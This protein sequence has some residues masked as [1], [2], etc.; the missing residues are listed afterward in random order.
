MSRLPPTASHGS[1][2]RDYA[3][4]EVVRTENGSG[5]REGLAHLIKSFVFL[6]VMVGIMVM[7]HMPLFLAPEEL[8]AVQILG[9]SLQVSGTTTWM[10]VVAV[11]DLLMLAA[12]GAMIYTLIQWLRF[13]RPRFTVLTL[14][15]RPGEKLQAVLEFSRGVPASGETC[16]ALHCI[17][18]ST[19]RSAYDD[20]HRGALVSLYRD[21][22]QLDTKGHRIHRL[23]FDFDL[24]EDVPSTSI[25]NQPCRIWRLIVRIPT[26]GLNYR[27]EFLVP[28]YDHED[29][30][31]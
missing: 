10:A 31:S 15:A 24:P 20:N 17:D 4:R 18:A 8:P 14:P 26:R 9:T 7:I 13:G 28:V 30:S 29:S 21:I 12:L 27:G 22:R 23:H 16:C 2:Q 1:W 11:F 6:P 25:Q 19:T 3:W 5:H